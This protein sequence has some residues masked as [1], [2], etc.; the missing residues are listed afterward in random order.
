MAHCALK[1]MMYLLLYEES[2]S[3]LDIVL[4]LSFLDIL[5]FTL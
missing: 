1:T 3:R 4:L 5:I 2:D